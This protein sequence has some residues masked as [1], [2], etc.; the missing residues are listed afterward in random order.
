MKEQEKERMK[1]AGFEST[2]RSRFKLLELQRPVWV[3]GVSLRVGGVNRI[4]QD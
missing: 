2:E 3:V 1:K 4:N